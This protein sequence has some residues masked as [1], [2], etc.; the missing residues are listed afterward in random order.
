MSGKPP[1]KRHMEYTA[2]ISQQAN[3]WL[4]Q[5]L[6]A[7]LTV[8]EIAGGCGK[9]GDFWPKDGMGRRGQSLLCGLHKGWWWSSQAQVPTSLRERRWK[10]QKSDGLVGTTS[11]QY[12]T[13]SHGIWAVYFIFS[14]LGWFHRCFIFQPDWGWYLTNMLGSPFQKVRKQWPPIKQPSKPCWSRGFLRSWTPN[15]FLSRW[16]KIRTTLW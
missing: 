6:H 1:S 4:P 3:T 13:R 8:C 7:G 16:S 2:S 15:L 12:P 9:T 14:F 11:T 5:S 10:L